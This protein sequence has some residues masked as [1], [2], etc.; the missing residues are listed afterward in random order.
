MKP[1]NEWEKEYDELFSL[2]ALHPD[3]PGKNLFK[4]ELKQFIS[5]LIAQTRQE[6]IKKVIE[7]INYLT[8]NMLLVD[9]LMPNR[10]QNFENKEKLLNQLREDYNIKDE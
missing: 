10:D 6:T 5:T 9:A 8:R 4:E 2:E 7:R 1:H 3:L